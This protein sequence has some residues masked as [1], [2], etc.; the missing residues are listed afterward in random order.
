M[1]MTI[2]EK[3]F[4]ASAGRDRVEPGEI[5]TVGIDLAVIHDG[6]GPIVYKQFRELGIPVWDNE[7]VVVAIDHYCLP[8][9]MENAGLVDES[10]QFAEDYN[11][12]NFFNMQG[13]A[14]QI[15]IENGMVL[16]G[17]IAVGTDSHTCTYGAL[18]AFS[19]GIGSTEMCAVIA[20]GRLWFKVPET[21]LV[22][23]NGRIP[24]K[25][26]SKDI[27]L[28]LLSMIGTNGAVYKTLQFAGDTISSLSMDER[29]T[30]C[31]MAIEA[32]AKNGII[33][34]DEKTIVYLNAAGVTKDYLMLKG[35]PDAVYADVV[36][37]DAGHLEPMIA[38]PFSPANGVPVQEK[39]GLKINQ[40]IIGAC[41][42]G[43]LGDIKIAAEIMK[44]KKVPGNIR[45]YIVPASNNVYAQAA[46]MGYLADLAEANCIIVNPGCGGCGIQMPM[47]AGQVCLATNNRNFCGRMGSQ[48]AGVYLASPLTAAV[49]AL[50]GRITDPR[51]C[52]C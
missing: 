22:R 1:G 45:C 49:S 11:I 29:F 34:P 28:K 21:I 18:G 30:L 2:T 37:I 42:N 9:T 27:M 47:T 12:K 16:P 10:C 52:I 20:T 38:V 39:E 3:I 33:E 41:T 25:I 7:K 43:R 24:D 4:A 19:S 48:D 40:V 14:H 35:D 26:T 31:N 46:R 50:R 5:V 32:G 13:V 6:L 44:G 36:D 8:G 51:K 17:Q 15:I 23:V